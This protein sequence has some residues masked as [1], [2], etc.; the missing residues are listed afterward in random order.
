MIKATI[1]FRLVKVNP[2]DLTPYYLLDIFGSNKPDLLFIEDAKRFGFGK[3]VVTS[4]MLILTHEDAVLAAIEMGLDEI[5]VLVADGLEEDEVPRFLNYKKR[6]QGK[7]DYAVIS[8]IIEFLY[9][10]LDNTIAGQEWKA[11]IPGENIRKK[12]GYLLG[13]NDTMVQHIRNIAENAPEYFPLLSTTEAKFSEVIKLASK[14]KRERENPNPNQTDT[15]TSQTGR[16]QSSSSQPAS[17]STPDIS[18]QDEFSQPA[19]TNQPVFGSVSTSATPAFE[20]PTLTEP[21]ENTFESV[22]KLLNSIK[23]TEKD[24][25]FIFSQPL[26]SKIDV[27]M[28]IVRDEETGLVV[29]QLQ[30]DPLK[31]DVELNEQFRIEMYVRKLKRA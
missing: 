24:G 19:I 31:S 30:E 11:V 17:F 25:Q 16:F 28:H 9:N 1:T 3:P 12:V 2:K 6:F 21:L 29:Y 15:S 4:K 27:S 10:H 20:Q 22:L 13:Y 8:K 23:G 7:K 26:S 5:E 18:Q 14:K